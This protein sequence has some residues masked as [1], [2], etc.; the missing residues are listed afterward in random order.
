MGL[1]SIFRKKPTLEMPVSNIRHW[2]RLELEKTRKKDKMDSHDVFV[3]ILFAV[4]T[5]VQPQKKLNPVPLYG[6]DASLFELWVFTFSIILDWHKE[7]R[8]NDNCSENLANESLRI[9]NA[10]LQ[11]K[12]LPLIVL[13]RLSV[14]SKCS[15]L[16]DKAEVAAGY[17]AATH[18]DTNPVRKPDVLG[19]G[20]EEMII[21]KMV[22]NIFAVSMANHIYEILKNYYR[23]QGN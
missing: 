1:F 22:T 19:V 14:Y 8:Q 9:F 23:Q 2:T 17:M 11:I 5:A 4:C 7:N 18:N 10:S 13:D 16:K 20:L 21:A 6:G 12:E 3:L 15:D